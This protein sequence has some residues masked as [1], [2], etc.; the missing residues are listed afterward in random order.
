ML[1]AQDPVGAANMNR[2]DSGYALKIPVDAIAEFRILTQTAP[3][4]IRRHGRRDYR[5][6]YAI[7]Q[8]RTAWLAL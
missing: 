4:E 7:R 1:R 3:P 6:R 5:R 2:M 8:Q